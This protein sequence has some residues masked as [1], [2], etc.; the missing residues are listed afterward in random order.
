MVVAS[1]RG[2]RK[3]GFVYGQR[4]G[5]K[6]FSTRPGGFRAAWEENT[7]FVKPIVTP[8][9]IAATWANADKTERVDAPRMKA[10]KKPTQRKPVNHQA[11]YRALKRAK[12][13]GQ[14]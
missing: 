7:V 8:E 14:K 3:F 2:A 11:R 4:Q 6:R 1:W 5:V 13:A 9:E 10:A 12:K